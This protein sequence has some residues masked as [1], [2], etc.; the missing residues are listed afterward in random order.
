MYFNGYAYSSP[1]NINL[2]EGLLRFGTTYSANPFG[3]TDKGLRLNASSQLVFW[4][5]TSSTTLGSAGSVVNFGLDDAYDDGSSINV[6]V[7]TITLTQTLNDTGIYL[8]KTGTGAGVPLYIAN[9]GTADDLWLYS[10]KAGAAGVV[11]DAHH[12]SASPADNDVIFELECNGDDDAANK[13]EYGSLQVLATDVTDA[14]EDA[15]FRLNLMLAGTQRQILNVNGDLLTYGSGTANAVVSSNGAYDLILETNEG[16]NSGTIRIYDGADGNIEIDANGTGDLTLPNTGI[17]Q[18]G[19]TATRCTFSV[20]GTTGA[21]F[22]VAS[23][24]ITSGDV[25]RINH[26]V[27]GT[28]N[29]GN[30]LSLQIDG[31]AYYSFGEVGMTIAGTEGSN[32]LSLTKGDQVVSDGSFLLTD[33]DNAAS[34][35]ITNNTV[36]TAALAVITGS[37]AFTGT[38]T[39]SFVS[40]TPSGLTT[41]TALYVACAVATTLSYAVDVTTSTTTGTALRLTNS[42]ILTGV[43]AA[44]SII[45]DSATTAGNATGEG[46][47]NISVD[48]LTTGAALNIESISNELLTSGVLAHFEHT[49][50]GTTVAAKT[51][52][53]VRIDSNI[54]ESGTSTQDFDMLSIVRRS[55]HDTA[56]TLTATGSLIYIENIATET[57]ATLTDTV[58]GLE[59]VMDAQGTGTGVKI[60]HPATTGKSVDVIASTTTGTVALLTMDSLTTT[61]VGLSLTNTGTGMTS[62]SV[63]RVSSGTTSA[64]ATNGV[65]SLFATGAFT[66]TAVT[67]G[68]V[69]VNG[70]STLSG[71]VVA[72]NGNSFTTGVGVY[73]GDTGTGMTSGS[74]IRAVSA[75]T[76]AVATN[77]VL[78][79][80]AT[81]AYTSTANMGILSAIAN[82]TTAGTVA[83]LSA[84]S[85]IGGTILFLNATAA[86]LTG[87]YIQCY[88]G[89]ADDFSVGQY[90]ATIIAGNAGS[91]VLTVTAGDASF[92]DSSIT[93]AD[94]DN[95]ITVGITNDTATTI[96]A[97]ANSGVVDISGDGLTTGTLLNLSV[98]EGT[99]A[100]GH[101]LKC[102]DVTGGVAVASIEEDGE[103]NIV[104]GR[105][106]TAGGADAINIGA[107]AVMKITWGSGVPTLVAPQGSLYLRTDGSS[108]TT[109]AYINTDGAATWTAVS[110]VA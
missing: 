76:G 31:T 8:N 96:G 33:D 71:T 36:T 106:T 24:S 1:R 74:L 83:Y 65:V 37:G 9:A 68:F 4:D 18:G 35:S 100:G 81:G 48:G 61:G 63:L 52:S 54:T 15:L 90:G 70:N 62:G 105:A 56:G 53:L 30:L 98:T 89:A 13:T 44:L 7:S 55:T 5:G 58:N 108:T 47:V 26:S 2:R 82:T 110:T 59:V 38:T 45:A 41:G 107:S 109:R 22:S 77:G 23:S 102:W 32:V 19:T 20:G 25:V 28:L 67:D 75:S 51:G 73:V 88:D 99:L 69:R 60:T 97:G 66:S 6:D 93:L 72:V 103:L 101:Y 10:T 84:T 42:G 92:A 43:G 86:T 39:S 94:N 85:M 11:I 104:G 34:F 14:T 29:G 95:A 3:S 50:S 12:K 21:G 80:Q 78:S 16:T 27:S 64:V 40:I 49:A 17:V 46:V 91:T 79:V 87:K 57:G